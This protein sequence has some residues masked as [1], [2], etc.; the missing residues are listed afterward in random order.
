MH[1]HVSITS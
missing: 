1:M